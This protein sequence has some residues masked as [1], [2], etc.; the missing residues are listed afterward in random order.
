M[1]IE[2]LV[3]LGLVA[4]ILLL[5]SIYANKHRSDSSEK[6]NEHNREARCVQPVS[7]HI[8]S[9]RLANLNRP[10][11]AQI[12]ELVNMVASVTCPLA[13][14]LTEYGSSIFIRLADG[15]EEEVHFPKG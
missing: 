2:S 11:E 14:R 5:V 15:R 8:Q 10:D 4:L 13:P 3:V 1:A 7:V 6:G 9:K 12:A